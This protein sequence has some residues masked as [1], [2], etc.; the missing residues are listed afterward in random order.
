MNVSEA[1]ASESVTFARVFVLVICT[2]PPCG[3]IKTLDVVSSAAIY[4]LLMTLPERRH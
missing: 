1:V 4:R 2:L 3:H